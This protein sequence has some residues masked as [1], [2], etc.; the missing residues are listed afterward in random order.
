MAD[1]GENAKLVEPEEEP[2]SKAQRL[3]SYAMEPVGT[4][5]DRSISFIVQTI[6]D[7]EKVASWHDRQAENAHNLAINYRDYL[8]KASRT[9]VPDNQKAPEGY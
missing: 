4:L 2:F 7:A 1:Y 6:L 9:G 3:D 5:A 8:A